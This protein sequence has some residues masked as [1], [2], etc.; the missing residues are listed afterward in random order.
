MAVACGELLE[1][2]PERSLA[3]GSGGSGGATTDASDSGGF[4][5][6]TSAGDAGADSQDADGDSPDDIDADVTD[7]DVTDADVTDADVTD[8]A[9]G[10]DGADAGCPQQAGV[11]FSTCTVVELTTPICT[12]SGTF[13]LDPDGTGPLAPFPAHCDLETDG[14]GWTLVLNYL[15]YHHTNPPVAVRPSSLP[16]YDPSRKLGTHDDSGT[17][18]W[19]HASPKLLDQLAPTELWFEGLSTLTPRKISFKTSHAGCLSYLRTGTGS[20]A[21]LE[22]SF[23]AFAD[24][25]AYLPAQATSFIPNKQDLALIEAPFY[26]LG[27]YHWNIMS[28]GER[29]EVDDWTNHHHNTHHRV[30]ARSALARPTSCGAVSA[31]NPSAKSGVY[32]ID[33]DGPGPVAALPTACTF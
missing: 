16:L 1:L 23:T 22:S 19:G 17:Q 7:A 2:G 11:V 4:G 12:P 3:P 30:L 5:G 32:A 25:T 31:L 15:H 21:G 10:A 14:G 27:K 26:V 20:C 6:E 18:Y 9:D 28:W 8:G 24:H 29:W 33:A 13:T